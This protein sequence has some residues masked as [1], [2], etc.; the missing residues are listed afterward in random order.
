MPI[1]VGNI[2]LTGLASRDAN[3]EGLAADLAP[4]NLDLDGFRFLVR[5]RA[6][7]AAGTAGWAPLAAAG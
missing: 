3:G 7:L 2:D 6:L 4:I 5:C 1:F